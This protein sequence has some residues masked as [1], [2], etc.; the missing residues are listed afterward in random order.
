MLLVR[1]KEQL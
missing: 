1:I